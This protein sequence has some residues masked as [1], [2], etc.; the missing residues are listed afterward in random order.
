MELS[1]LVELPTEMGGIKTW[2]KLYISSDLDR[3][4]VLGE[5]GLK[6]NWT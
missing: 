4:S 5:D 2:S 3:T 1:S 6:K